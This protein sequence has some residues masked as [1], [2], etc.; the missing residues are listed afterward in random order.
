VGSRTRLTQKQSSAALSKTL[1]KP[2]LEPISPNWFKD[3]KILIFGLG[4]HDAGVGAIEYLINQGAAITITDV[5]TKE[6]LLPSI[7]KLEKYQS[8]I[9]YHLGGHQEKDFK[10]HDLIIK[11]VAIPKENP[12]LK[13][14]EKAGLLIETDISLFFKLSPS[15]IVGITGTKGKTTTTSLVYLL[16]KK[17]YPKKVVLGGNIRKSVL[18]QLPKLTDKHLA[19]LE[20]SSFQ[21]DS[22]SLANRSPNVSIITNIYPDHL[23]WHRNIKDYVNA[24]KNIFRFQ[25]KDDYAVFNFDNPKTKNITSQFEAK[26]IPFSLI[27]KSMLYYLDKTGQVWE[28]GRKMTNVSRFPLKGK[29]NWYNTV[30]AIAGTRLLGVSKI[31]IERVLSTFKAPSGRQEK[32]R[33]LKGV[34]F[35]NDTTATGVEAMVAALERF[36]PEY[37]KKLVFISGGVDKGV[38]YRPIKSLVKKYLK[39]LVLLEGTA[40][41]K[42][43]E[44]VKDVPG[45]IIKKYFSDFQK[46]IKRAFRLASAGDAVILCPGGASFNMFQHEFDRGDQFV[47]CVKNL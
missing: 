28:K 11:S 41:E 2:R 8:K 10:N 23:N 13:I 25:K 24:K 46:A 6:E 38:D 21:L 19:V 18:R 31:N 47:A 40:S 32:V 37:P 12:W 33:T 5:K 3:K 17:Q 9:V 14:A 4:L 42:I 30:A 20:L 39:A 34:S 44:T 22:L 35:Y 26:K 16:L 1:L 45:L 36:G 27:K 43:F 15:K 7:K 29:H